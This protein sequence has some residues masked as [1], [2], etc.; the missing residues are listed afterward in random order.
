MNRRALVLVAGLLAPQG[1]AGQAAPVLRG[2][3]VELGGFSHRVTNSYGN[4]SGVRL[5]AVLPVGPGS[6]FYLEGVG[7][8]AFHDEGIY[9]SGAIQQAIGGDWIG[10]LGVGGGTGD[11]YFPDLRV[12]ATLTRK[13]LP[14][15]RLLISVGGTWVRSKDVYRDRTATAA[16]TAYL[17]SA[18]V[19][20]AGG[21]FNWSTPG[22]VTSRRGALALTMGRAGQRYL[23]LRG[24]GGTEAYQLT[25][26][27][28]TEQKFTSTEA[29]L[30]WREWLGTRVGFVL[31]G[32]WYDNPYYTRTGVQLGLFAG[33]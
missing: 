8:R 9:T 29:S 26:S 1:V 32:E 24:A 22:E 18:V 27:N 19:V 14:S 13:L 7:Q 21:R 4:W 6:V 20:E 11:F 30:S 17:G 15:R 5:R 10:Y 31:G 12:D 23:V 16:I 28:A 3:L 25:G 33:W 2:G